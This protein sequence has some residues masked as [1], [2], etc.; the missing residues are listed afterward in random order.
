MRVENTS[1]SK[2]RSSQIAR[3]L[4]RAKRNV[5]KAESGCLGLSGNG[6]TKSCI[7]AFTARTRGRRYRIETAAAIGASMSA[8]GVGTPRAA[9]A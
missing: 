8:D 7:R 6:G 3:K 2:Q 5:A 1:H 9:R 4:R